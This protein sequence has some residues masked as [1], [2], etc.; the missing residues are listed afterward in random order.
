MSVDYGKDYEEGLKTFG[1]QIRSRLPGI[2][3][4]HKGST[5]RLGDESKDINKISDETPVT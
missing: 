1:V 4:D 5:A 2:A 3:R